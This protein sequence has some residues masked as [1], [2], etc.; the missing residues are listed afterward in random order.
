MVTFT[1]ETDGCEERHVSG[2][3]QERR[4][5]LSFCPKEKAHGDA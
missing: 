4:A 3:G 1:M 2:R 5:G